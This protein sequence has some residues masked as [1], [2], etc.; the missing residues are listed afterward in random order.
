[1]TSFAAWL[2]VQTLILIFAFIVTT[3]AAAAQSFAA[4]S[5]A[6]PPMAP[7]KVHQKL[8]NR[9]VGKGIKV[10]EV[11]GT[12]IKGVLVSIDADSFQITAQ[13]ATQPIA[14][15]NAQVASLSNTGLSTAAKIGIGVGIGIVAVIAYIIIALKASGY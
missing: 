12:V 3:T 5:S 9:T 2:R 11:D 15:L 6:T 14:I 4:Q 10:T 8:I 13:H 1:M 7:A